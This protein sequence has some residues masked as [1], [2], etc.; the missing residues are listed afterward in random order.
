MYYNS[1]ASTLRYTKTLALP[2][3]SPSSGTAVREA[4]IHPL[5]FPHQNLRTAP[6]PHAAGR[7]GRLLPG[8]GA[9]TGL[10]VNSSTRLAVRELAPGQNASPS[11]WCAPESGPGACA[12]SSFPEERSAPA[13]EGTATALALRTALGSGVRSGGSLGFARAPPLP[14]FT[15][16]AAVEAAAAA[17]AAAVPRPEAHPP[18][19]GSRL[20]LP[21]PRHQRAP[22][23]LR[24][25]CLERGG[26]KAGGGKGREGGG[27]RLL[28]DLRHRRAPL[29]SRPSLE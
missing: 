16:D 22:P 29:S 6:A 7:V 17:A 21:L 27:E 24:A 1:Q 19:C 3:S 25:G 26:E 13:P 9:V 10:E 4:F 12:S 23:P 20:P 8:A 11:G 28:G 18:A 15:S 2:P 14:L 5:I